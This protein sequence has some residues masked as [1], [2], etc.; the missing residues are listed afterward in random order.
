MGIYIEKMM[1]HGENLMTSLYGKHSG[2][3]SSKRGRLEIFLYISIHVQS[4]SC[5]VDIHSD[6]IYK[7]TRFNQNENVHPISLLVSAIHQL[8]G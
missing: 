5:N 6:G 4:F 2:E 8:H 3:T 1:K 7:S